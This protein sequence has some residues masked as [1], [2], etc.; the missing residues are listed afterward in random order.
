MSFGFH[1]YTVTLLLCLLMTWP[2]MPGILDL[3]SFKICLQGVNFVYIVFY[4]G[5]ENI[6]TIKYSAQLLK[7]DT[8]TYSSVLCGVTSLNCAC[9]SPA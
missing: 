6:S 4:M 5:N 8:L 3:V 2:A 9:E 1:I 7:P